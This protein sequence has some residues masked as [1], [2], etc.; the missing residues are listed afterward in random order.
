MKKTRVDKYTIVSCLGKG[1]NAD[2]YIVRDGKNNEYALKELRNRNSREGRQRFVNEI[3]IVKK[4]SNR[5]PGIIPVLDSDVDQLWYT[6]PIAKPIMEIVAASKIEE[7]VKGVVQLSETLEKLHKKGVYHRDIKPNNIYY[8]NNRYSFG[9]FGLVDF[10]DNDELTKSNKGLGAVFTIAPEMKRDPK[11]AD[12]SKADVYSLAKTL[13]IFLSN[14]KKG[15]DGVYDYLDRSHSLRFMPEYKDKHTVEIDEL[16]RESTQNVPELRP[17]ISDFKRKLSEWL[18]IFLDE[19]RSQNSEWVFIK[20]MIF[21][22]NSPESA[23]WRNK[24]D[25]IDVLNSVGSNPAYNHMLF[26]SGG[27]LDFKFCETANEDGFIYLYDNMGLCHLLKP[28]KL[29]YE[30]FEED[31]RWSYFLLEINPIDPIISKNEKKE[32][33]YLVEDVPGHYVDARYV[34]YG[35][36]DY[37]TGE[38][39]PDGYKMVC[40]YTQGKLLLVLKGGPYNRINGTYD[41]RHGFCSSDE[42]RTYVYKLL[43]YYCIKKDKVVQTAKDNDMLNRDL[44]ERILNSDFFNNNPFEVSNDKKIGRVEDNEREIKKQRSLYIKNQYSKWN[45]SIALGGCPQTGNIKYYFVIENSEDLS[46]RE[47]K[48]LMDTGYFCAENSN[49]ATQKRYY[50]SSIEGVLKTKERLND[51][52]KSNLSNT[53]YPTDDYN[54]SLFVIELEKNGAP[55]HLFTKEEIRTLMRNA[56]DRVDNV[57]VVD[58]DGYAH[59]IEFSE[60]AFLYPV[61]QEAW[62]AGN[63]YVGKYSSLSDLEDSYIGLLNGWLEYLKYKSESFIDYVKDYDEQKLLCEIRKYY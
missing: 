35:V 4:Y 56:D 5:I 26:S 44:E 38:K 15:F 41:G 7:I 60:T 52:I 14:N 24:T 9:D 47:R 57:L 58:S 46:K 19:E 55:L 3:T 20:K 27:G 10:P 30:S 28:H 53:S 33:E 42:F 21:G 17:T 12:A 22:K 8:Y 13:W 50:V 37:D 39:L 54:E 2:V 63:N 62:Q 48:V 45:Y 51:V 16:L 11:R 36:Y 1:G 34:Q 23:I 59:I 49:D 29:V 6:M 31:Y 40:R 61:R 43:H 32:Y 25:I 18:D